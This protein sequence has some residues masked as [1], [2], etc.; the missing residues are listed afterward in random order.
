MGLL[1]A[2]G[3]WLAAECSEVPEVATVSTFGPLAGIHAFCGQ[4]TEAAAGAAAPGGGMAWQRPHG[5]HLLQGKLVCSLGPQ[6]AALVQ[7]TPLPLT[8]LLLCLQCKMLRC[9]ILG[10]PGKC[11]VVG[12]QQGGGVFQEP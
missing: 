2:A 9:L 4:Q 6:M 11:T 10:I 12:R 5:C 7:D 1:A 3:V 8:L